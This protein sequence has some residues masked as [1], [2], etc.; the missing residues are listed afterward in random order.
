MVK[1]PRVAAVYKR[2][3]PAVID[4]AAAYEAA[5]A[6]ER[7]ASWSDVAAGKAC[8]WWP[9]RQTLVVLR[10]ECLPSW[11]HCRAAGDVEVWHRH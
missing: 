1:D 4:L 2:R 7:N 5:E 11:R 9:A 3:R 10:K 8:G 6:R